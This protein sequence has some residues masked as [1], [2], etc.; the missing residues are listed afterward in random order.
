MILLCA[1]LFTAVRPAAA[2][3]T[4]T[5]TDPVRE[6]FSMYAAA[7]AE[8]NA[9]AAG[10]TKTVRR[11]ATLKGLTNIPAVDEAL[12]KTADAYLMETA[13][14]YLRGDEAAEA[15]PACGEAALPAI[16]EATAREENG[17]TVFS[18]VFAGEEAPLDVGKG[19]L[20]AVTDLAASYKTLDERIG[21]ISV[22]DGAPI[23]RV[24][25]TGFTIEGELTPDG[26]F[27]RVRHAVDIRVQIVKA[28]LYIS[29]VRNRAF[30]ATAAAEYTDFTY[31]PARGDVNGDG[32]VTAQ[33][34]RLALRRAVGLE[35]FGPETD[36]WLAADATGDGKVT[37]AD[38]R[39]ILRMAVGLTEDG[40]T[41]GPAAPTEPAE[42]PATPRTVSEIADF[43]RNAI[44]RVKNGEAGFSK[45]EWQSVSGVRLS[46]VPAVDAQLQSLADG[47]FTP[48]SAAEA[49][50][51]EKGAEAAAQLP[52]FT[53]TDYSRIAAAT[54]ETVD[55]NYE[56]EIRMKDEDTPLR[57]NSALAEVGRVLYWD[58]IERELDKI[59]VLQGYDDVRVIYMD[60]TIRATLTPDGA[61]RRL[62]HSV[63][64]E[65][66]VGT[67]KILFVEI[68]NRSLSVFETTEYTDF[69]C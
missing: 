45:R 62:S 39:A 10:F 22:I 63:N 42:P 56:L 23:Y 35:D 41:P 9:G 7:A 4:E 34:A 21:E 8:I 53:L 47:Y 54:C 50:Y 5:E 31:A 68:Q 67:A 12:Q 44:A 66:R 43:Y 65:V 40:K 69:T 25:Y 46:G 38:A 57:E 19:A 20:A 58:E 33:D 52:D 32:G 24:R 14:V 11:T 30:T 59:P 49:V 2:A 51:Y 17:N 6:I 36:A 64:A 26:R 18:I 27:A 55:G 16:R 15:F 28:K 29:E 13:R 61:F 37:A 60:Y 1:L 48:E 3:E